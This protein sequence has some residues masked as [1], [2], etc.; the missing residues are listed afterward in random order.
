MFKSIMHEKTGHITTIYLNRPEKLNSLNSPMCTEL[1][2]AINKASD[3]KTRVMLIKAKGRA[4]CS[5]ADLEEIQSVMHDPDRAKMFF[6]TINRVFFSLE[7]APYPVIAAVNGLALTGGLELLM[8]CDITIASEGSQLGDHSSNY[9]LIPGGGIQRLSRII[10]IHR[11]KYLMLTGEWLSAHEALE[12]GLVNVVV[13]ESDL[14]KTAHKLAA[15]L[16]DKS[17]LVNQKVKRI[18]RQEINMNIKDA[19]ELEIFNAVEHLRS[20]DCITGMESFEQRK[21]PVFKGE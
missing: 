6:D 20:A 14:E 9:G 11:A 10:G 13:P 18:I 2:T 19:I 8:A 1:I 12:I 16:A 21:K 15:N 4:F 7:E 5:G 3:D 17:P